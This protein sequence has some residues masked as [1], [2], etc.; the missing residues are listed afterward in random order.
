MIYAIKAKG[1][2]YI[3]FGK[4][5]RMDRRM[6]Q[7]NVSTPFD[8]E[9]LAVADWPDGEEA[10]VHA[11]LRRD[12]IK[13][14]WFQ[15]SERTS[16]VVTLLQSSIGLELWHEITRNGSLLSSN[17]LRRALALEVRP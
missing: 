15:I 17:R 8:L 6:A 14:E 3:K 16:R 12:W 4:S 7:M 13:G 11:F 1:T 2:R 5:K 9:L 10:R